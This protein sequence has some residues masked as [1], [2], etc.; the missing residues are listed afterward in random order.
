M[1]LAHALRAALVTAAIAGA[2]ALGT[3]VAQADGPAVP[4]TPAG[5]TAPVATPSPS[6]TTDTN[7]WD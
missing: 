1:N 7:P 4:A 2:A 3:Q 6:T 5:T